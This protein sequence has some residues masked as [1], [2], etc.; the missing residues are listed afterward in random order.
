MN[1]QNLFKCFLWFF[2]TGIANTAHALLPDCEKNQSA[3]FGKLVCQN[4]DLQKLN[5]EIQEKYLSAQLMSNAP[6]TLLRQSQQD[7]RKYVALC[8]NQRCL[9]EQFEKRLDDL[10]FIIN[11]NQSLTQ[12]FIRY[13]PKQPKQQMVTLQ[14]Q[15]L[16]KN[17]I[18]IEA[19][20]YRNPNNSEHQRIA[21][22]R[23][24]TSTQL[25]NQITDLETKCT[26]TLQRSGHLLNFRTQDPKCER[27][28]GIYKLYD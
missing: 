5:L 10:T 20:Q 2:C 24:Y 12:H 4:Q 23:S 13:A 15:Q 19:S 9:K 28:V 1:S 18:K 27:F 16:D 22:L 8:K 21:Y 7:W 17:K 3:S 6:L 26:Y 25:Q 11:M 14:I